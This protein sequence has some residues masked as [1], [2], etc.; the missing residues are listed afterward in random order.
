MTYE[1]DTLT[2]IKMIFELLSSAFFMAMLG[3]VIGI[4]IGLMLKKSKNNKKQD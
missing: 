1:H 2:E 3:V 4:G